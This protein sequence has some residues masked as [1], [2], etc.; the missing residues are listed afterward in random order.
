MT[1]ALFLT[2]PSLLHY[3]LM[4]SYWQTATIRRYGGETLRFGRAP[5]RC[6][7][8]YKHP[9]NSLEHGRTRSKRM[10]LQS[11]TLRHAEGDVVNQK[12]K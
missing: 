5:Q 4:G 7:P 9:P 6:D 3:R 8:C 11:W 2:L 10:R 1:R 12:K